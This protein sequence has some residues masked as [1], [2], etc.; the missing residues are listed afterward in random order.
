MHH[1]QAAMST[2]KL[3]QLMY[4]AKQQSNTYLPYHV[5]CLR[6]GELL[7]DGGAK[8]DQRLLE[9]PRHRFTFAVADVQKGHHI[10]QWQSWSCRVAIT[11]CRQTLHRADTT[12]DRAMRTRD[13][14]TFKIWL[15]GCSTHACR[16]L[17]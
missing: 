10:A 17:T 6:H 3:T 1:V 11:E 9:W 8:L 2:D 12:P 5:C 14:H 7:L 4:R 16:F 15:V 13:Q